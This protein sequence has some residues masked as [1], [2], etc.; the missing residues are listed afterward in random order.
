MRT[1]STPPV[2]NDSTSERVSG[3]GGPSTSSP[4]SRTPDQTNSVPPGATNAR[5]GGDRRR[6]QR[7]RHRLDGDALEHEVERLRPLGRAGRAGRRRGSRRA[8]PGSAGGRSRRRSR[9]C[10]TPWWRSPGSAISSA[11]SPVPLPTTRA[12]RPAPSSPRAHSS[13]AGLGAPRCHGISR[14]PRSAARYSGSNQ[15][16][17]PPSSRAPQRDLA[18]GEHHEQR[19][20]R[21]RRGGEEHRLQRVGDA[22]AQAPG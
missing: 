8:S 7:H 14:S 18:Q 10:R 22:V 19:G 6:A 4:S 3:H 9:R 2:A 21:D 20:E 15:S 13:I 16:V 12:R 11:S 1:G 17:M 5:H